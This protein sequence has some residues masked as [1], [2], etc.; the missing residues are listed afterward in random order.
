ME[1]QINFNVAATI[2]HNFMGECSAIEGY[3]QFLDM[4]K[5]RAEW[6]EKEDDKQQEYFL[7]E[8]FMSDLEEIISD[9]QNHQQILQGWYKKFSGIKP[10]T[11]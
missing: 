9:E 4:L 2:Q 7:L 1:K 8:D 10:A 11:S 3:S 5:N 6:I